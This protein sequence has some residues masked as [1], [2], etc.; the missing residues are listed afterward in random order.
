MREVHANKWDRRRLMTVRGAIGGLI[1]G[2]AFI[3][4]QMWFLADAEMPANTVIHL[5]ATIVQP[6]EYFTA[7]TSLTVGWLV[8]IGLSLAYGAILGFA[9]T[10]MRSNIT[11]VAGASLYGL[12]IYMFNFLVLAPLFYELF[13]TANQ[14]FE[15]TVHI[16]FGALIAPFI[17]TW[18]GRH[19]RP[20]PA[21]APIVQQWRDNGGQV[22]QDVDPASANRPIQPLPPHTTFDDRHLR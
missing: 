20:E 13:T 12:G 5:I 3:L 16:V 7:R 14:P 8:H 11:R 15:A 4:L 18:T 21:L 2:L 17:V 1:A 22:P 9:A 6:D 19:A 10:E